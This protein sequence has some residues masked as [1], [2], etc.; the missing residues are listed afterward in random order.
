MEPDS[1]QYDSE[2]IHRIQGGEDAAFDLLYGRHR[3]WVYR[4]AYR[5]TGNDADAWDVVQET[6]LYLA[7]KKPSLRLTASL[8]TLL[9]P[10]VRNNAIKA[11]AKRRR[12]V[13]GEELLAALPAASERESGELA[14]ILTKLELPFR[15]ILIL[16]YVDDLTIPEIAQVLEIPEGTAKSRLFH[17]HRLVREN[18]ALRK[19]FENL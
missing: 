16:R 5:F 10:V 18:P 4:L 14:A 6:F 15:Q 1:K 13:A 19:Y 9:F 12:L 2:L 3:Q 8:R 17:A 11:N 7:R